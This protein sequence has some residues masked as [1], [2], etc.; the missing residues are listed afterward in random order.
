MCVFDNETADVL[1]V[2]CL[3]DFAKDKSCELS[4]YKLSLFNEVLPR[5]RIRSSF[6]VIGCSVLHMTCV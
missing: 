1:F 3:L 5:V 6:D 2:R 4:N